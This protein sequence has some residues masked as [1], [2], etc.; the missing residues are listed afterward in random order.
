MTH[1]PHEFGAL[2]QYVNAVIG[3]LEFLPSLNDIF[4]QL[5]SPNVTVDLIVV[6]VDSLDVSANTDIFSLISAF[7]T[8]LSC[9]TYPVPPIVIAA[10]SSSNLY[11]VKNAMDTVIRGVIS[12]DDVHIDVGIDSI[13]AG[14]FYIS[15][16]IRRAMKP[17]KEAINNDGNLTHRQHQVLELIQKRGACNKSIAKILNIAESTVKL[18]VTAILKKFGV[19]TR[20]QLCTIA[21]RLDY[22]VV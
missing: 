20:T 5:C 6:D 21:K 7:N 17:K 13:L 9:K 11:I 12:C 3:E 10:K 18:H 14:T 2:Q 1:N 19:R 15:S 16:N 4:A 8:L 22:S